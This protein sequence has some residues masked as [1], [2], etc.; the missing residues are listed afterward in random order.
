MSAAS[1]IDTI[2][3]RAYDSGGAAH[4]YGRTERFLPLSELF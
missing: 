3:Q 4:A 1:V 2:N